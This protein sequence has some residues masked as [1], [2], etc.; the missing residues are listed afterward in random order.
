MALP[1]CH[2][3]SRKMPEIAHCEPIKPG[4]TVQRRWQRSASRL[5]ISAINIFIK[6]IFMKKMFTNPQFF[7]TRSVT[8]S[9]NSGLSGPK[10]RARP[11]FKAQCHHQQAVNQ[12]AIPWQ[13]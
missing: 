11:K 7:L 5:A 1:G 4:E 9:N 13:T 10:Q 12:G 2:R 3:Q 8:V 6:K